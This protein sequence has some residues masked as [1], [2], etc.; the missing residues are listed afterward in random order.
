MRS[1]IHLVTFLTVAAPSLQAT[2]ARAHNSVIPCAPCPPSNRL[3][4]HPGVLIPKDVWCTYKDVSYKV[5]QRCKRFTKIYMPKLGGSMGL[6]TQTKR[7]QNNTPICFA[8]LDKCNGIVLACW[9]SSLPIYGAGKSPVFF[10]PSCGPLLADCCCLSCSSAGCHRH[11]SWPS[12]FHM[13]GCSTNHL[14]L[15]LGL[16]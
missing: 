5:L 11:A 4:S 14:G 16:G 15:G 1:S 9:K 6:K 8:H 13:S 2:L 12:L 7:H 3:Q 10:P